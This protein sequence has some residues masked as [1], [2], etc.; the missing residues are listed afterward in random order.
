MIYVDRGFEGRVRKYIVVLG[1]VLTIISIV[2]NLT[3]L[4]NMLLFCGMSIVTAAFLYFQVARF[5]AMGIRMGLI[6]IRDVA[7]QE[8]EQQLSDIEA[9]IKALDA[10][11]D[12]EIVNTDTESKVK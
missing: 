4:Q 1:I 8:E 2:I 11:L 3:D 5:A 6:R 7:E 12:A 9:E 10:E